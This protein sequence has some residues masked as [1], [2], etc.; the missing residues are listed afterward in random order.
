MSLGLLSLLVLWYRPFRFQSIYSQ[1]G[2]FL[3]FLRKEK[4]LSVCCHPRVSLDFVTCIQVLSSRHLYQ[5]ICSFE[6]QRPS[7]PVGPPSW[8]LVKVL[9]CLCGLVFEPLS[10]KPLQVF[11]IKTLVLAPLLQP[12][13]WGSVRPF[14]ISKSRYLFVIFTWICGQ[15]EVCEESPSCFSLVRSLSEFVGDLPKEHLLCP[16]YAVRIYL[17]TTTSLTLRPRSLFVSPRCL[18]RALSK[19]VLLLFLRQV[20][21][22]AGAIW[23]ISAGP[24]RAHSVRGVATLAVFLCNWSVVEAATWR[25]NPVFATFYFNDLS[26]SL[27][28]CGSLGPFC[29]C[30]LSY[31][32]I[33]FVC[34][35]FASSSPVASCV[36]LPIRRYLP[37][38]T[39]VSSSSF[40]L[41]WLGCGFGLIRPWTG[42]LP[43][44]TVHHLTSRLLL[45]P[46]L[47]YGPFALL[48]CSIAMTRTYVDNQESLGLFAYAY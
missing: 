26:S 35:R 3:L 45:C 10:S 38:L 6:L 32:L 46:A 5:F 42:Y 40:S 15:N 21:S 41:G 33:V 9:E 13:G 37:F 30:E 28:N 4:H 18:L 36:L 2:G 16:V 31:L 43:T 7:A 24:P 48:A 12:N 25:S 34:I 27:G 44:L 47:D 1:V 29:S 14:R 11:S 8:D 20:I 17:D 23:D 19:N 39:F 22:D